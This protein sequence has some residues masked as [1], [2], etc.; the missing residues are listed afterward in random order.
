[1]IRVKTCQIFRE[2]VLPENA[3]PRHPWDL[4]DDV[5]ITQRHFHTCPSCRLW[6]LTIARD[7]PTLLL[8]L[9]EEP[10][11]PIHPD[12][13]VATMKRRRRMRYVAA[14]ALFLT[15]SLSFIVPR[16]LVR[17]TTPPAYMAHI[18]STTETLQTPIPP[19][20]EKAPPNATVYTLNIEG[21]PLVLIYTGADTP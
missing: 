14:A 13:F 12:R 21:T 17:E 2:T 10:P 9:G 11:V 7:D 20:V 16:F 8:W 5:T 1:M 6:L 3:S 18:S 19:L 15:L 4:S